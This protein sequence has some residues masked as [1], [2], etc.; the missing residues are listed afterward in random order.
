MFRRGVHVHTLTT[1]RAIHRSSYSYIKTVQPTSTLDHAPLALLRNLCVFVVA[2]RV[3]I[4]IL[5][6]RIDAGDKYL[7]QF[8]MHSTWFPFGIRTYCVVAPLSSSLNVL[9]T[10]IYRYE[11]QRG[12]LA[13]ASPYWRH[14]YAV[15]RTICA[16]HLWCVRTHWKKCRLISISIHQRHINIY[17]FRMIGMNGI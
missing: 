8:N 7:I 14:L 17:D 13:W 10:N 9:Q 2:I 5:S 6:F 1:Y 15:C 16:M 4:S 3:A 12:L 11:I